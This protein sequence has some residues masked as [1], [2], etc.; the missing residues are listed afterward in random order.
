MVVVAGGFYALA[1]FFSPRY[2]VLSTLIRN[3]RTSLRIVCE[4]L[5]SMLYRLEEL[6]SSR[7]LET[8][9]ALEAVGNGLLA[10]LAL[11][12]VLRDGLLVQDQRRLRLTDTGRAAASQLVRTHRLWE[13]YLVQ[14][15]GLA[16]DHVHGPAHRVEHFIDAKIQRD[17]E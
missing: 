11:A 16:L 6:D 4:D 9:A 17:L 8:R 14:H 1:V 7:N 3:A 15:L 13:A 10:R 5:L 12:S 2:G